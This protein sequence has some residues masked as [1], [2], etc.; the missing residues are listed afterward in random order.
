MANP[1]RFAA[2]AGP[3]LDAVPID[4]STDDVDLTDPAGA[5]GGYCCRAIYVGTGGTVV[6]KGIGLPNPGAGYSVANRTV[7]V[8]SATIVIFSAQFV[9]KDSTASGLLALL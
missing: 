9:S 7:T 2:S 4:V 6:F 5:T 3:Y 8:A 1:I